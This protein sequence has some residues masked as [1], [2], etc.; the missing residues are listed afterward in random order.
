LFNK[1][2]PEHQEEVNKK[3]AIVQRVDVM[4]MH[5]DMQRAEA[6]GLA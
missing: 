2:K 4:M 1:L 5:L 6:E 3:A